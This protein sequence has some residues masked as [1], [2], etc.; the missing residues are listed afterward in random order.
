MD[1]RVRLRS[2]VK[3]DFRRVLRLATGATFLYAGVAGM[4]L[5]GLAQ[6]S[7]APASAQG[8]SAGEK[9]LGV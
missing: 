1:C 2:K 4:A 6:V 9:D 8:A 5:A 3:P 7:A